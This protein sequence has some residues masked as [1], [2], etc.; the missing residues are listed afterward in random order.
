MTTLRSEATLVK[1]PD[2]Q[3]VAAGK[4]RSERA[5]AASHQHECPDSLFHV[6]KVLDE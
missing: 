2:E 1:F 3:S 5:S 4:L 6:V